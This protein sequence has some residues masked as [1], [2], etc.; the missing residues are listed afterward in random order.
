MDQ[1][2]CLS[3][4]TECIFILRNLARNCRMIQSSKRTVLILSLLFR[5]LA[6]APEVGQSPTNDNVKWNF[7]SQ[8][9]KM[10][11][12]FYC[13]FVL[14]WNWF[15]QAERKLVVLEKW[16]PSSI[17]G[18]KRE[19]QKECWIKLHVEQPRGLYQTPLLLL[20]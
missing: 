17:F 8:S 18:P 19:Q 11:C 10:Y 7:P 1:T 6:E 16:V 13:C 5:I 2:C 3:G 4:Q 15:C 14:M 12:I 20:G 9:Y